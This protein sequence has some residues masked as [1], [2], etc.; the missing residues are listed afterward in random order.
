MSL[1]S[2][3]LL[4]PRRFRLAQPAS[5]PRRSG[6]RKAPPLRWTSA[7]ATY[8]ICTNP[9]SG[10]WL[11]S[12]GLVS[13]GLAGNPR[14]WFNIAEEQ[15]HR[16]Q[17]RMDHATNLSFAAYFELANAESTTSNGVSG[18]KLHYYQLA[19]L[20]RKVGAAQSV[21][22]LTD[23]KM[24][25]QCFPN[26]GTLWLTRRDKVRQAISLQIAAATRRWWAIE[27]V[28]NPRAAESANP[29]FDPRAIARTEAIL[30]NNDSKWQAFFRANGMSPFV[31]YYEDLMADYPG[32]IRSILNWLGVPD[33]ETVAVPAPR[34]TRQSNARNEDWLA[35]YLDFKS[36]RGLVAPFPAVEEKADAKTADH[37]PDAWKE[38][39]GHSRLL[40]IGDDAMVAV[41]TGNGYAK[42][43]ALAEVKKAGSD[44]YLRAAA[45]TY[46]R[47]SKGA[48]LL[49]ALGRMARL[50]SRAKLIDRCSILS[51]DEFRDGHYAANRPVIMQGLMSDWRA[52]QDWTPTTLKS[53]AANRVV[54]VMIRAPADAK[55]R[56]NARV[57]RTQMRFSEYV[58]SVYGLKGADTVCMAPS[59]ELLQA[60]A[61]LAGVTGLPDYLNPAAAASDSFLALEPANVG[62]R[63]ANE[64]RNVLYAQVFGRKRYRLVPASQWQYVYNRTGTSSEVDAERPDFGRTPKFRN[65]TVME[66]VVEPGEVLFLPVG[67]WRHVRT[68]EVSLTVSFANFIFPNLFSW[69]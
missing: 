23:A 39:I 67:W 6:A 38:W 43:A 13:T 53:A 68:L 61:L 16:A 60:P 45:E 56:A 24:L 48:A 40:Q 19:E 63:L 10:S 64:P 49:N 54:E 55:H 31:L 22:E 51:R 28:A 26:A 4:R 65:A 21:A 25:A 66:I 58:D 11:L 9:R 44:P 8:L 52:M 57:Q 2:V 14:E 42:E 46:R 59:S 35:R 27:G 3:P 12:E 1:R 20:T 30:L 50:D 47:C 69:E 15:R 5:A 18:I 7:T 36:R 37:I 62:M 33:A 17:W 32:A 41:L 29:E 34:L